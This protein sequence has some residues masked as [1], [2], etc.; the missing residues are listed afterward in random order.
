M[1][2][3][4]LQHGTA[5]IPYPEPPY[6]AAP[7]WQPPAGPP[8]P[9]PPAPRRRWILPAA[10]AAA[11]LLVGT[12]LGIVVGRGTSN[13]IT[14][15][16]VTTTVESAP[17]PQSFTDADSA[18]CREYQATST[19][20]ADAGESGG[21]PRTLASPDLPATAWTPEE[22]KANDAFARYSATWTPGLAGLQKSVANPTLKSLVDGMENSNATLADKVLAR[23][24]VPA[25]F[26]LY[27]D[28]SAN[29]NAILAICDRI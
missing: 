21:A 24:Y 10:V 6:G 28:V 17:Q 16:P 8:P 12:G 4:V 11:T 13:T 26:Q 15:E 7:G 3:M 14:S 27:R 29:S 19:R 5:P 2:V 9:P 23:T 20:I 18:W 25:D 1:T 22:V